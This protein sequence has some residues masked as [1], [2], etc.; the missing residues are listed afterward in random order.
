MFPEN[1][2]IRTRFTVETQTRGIKGCFRVADN[3]VAQ[4]IK[5]KKVL[6]FFFSRALVLELNS[7]LYILSTIKLKKCQAVRPLLNISAIFLKYPTL[8]KDF[9]SYFHGQ[10]KYKVRVFVHNYKLRS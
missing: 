7:K 1:A 10:K 9:F 8:D 2:N 4:K 3:I 5:G 6:V